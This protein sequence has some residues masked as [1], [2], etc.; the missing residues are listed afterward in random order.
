MNSL[1]NETTRSSKIVVHMRKT[2]LGNETMDAVDLN[3]DNDGDAD[4]NMG[5]R[6]AHGVWQTH[7]PHK[8]ISIKTNRP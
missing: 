2:H 8:L 7:T 5:N 1:S 3:A 6:S 4:D